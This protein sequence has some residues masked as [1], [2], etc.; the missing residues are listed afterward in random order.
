MNQVGEG[1]TMVIS[2]LA[3]PE[4]I[5]Q[6]NYLQN[7]SP[8]YFENMRSQMENQ[9]RVIRPKS[10]IENREDAH[11]QIKISRTKSNAVKSYQRG[12]RTSFKNTY[13]SPSD[14]LYQ[15][16]MQEYRCNQFVLKAAPLCMIPRRTTARPLS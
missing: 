6:L 10:T 3:S 12:S 16:Q 4:A 5:R 11:Q 2:S 9:I 8:Q 7:A 13:S 15:H 1:S 14:L